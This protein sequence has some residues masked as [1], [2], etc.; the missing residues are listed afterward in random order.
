MS[1]SIKINGK[2]CE[3]TKAEAKMA[4]EIRISSIKDK[5]ASYLVLTSW[6]DKA[7]SEEAANRRL[8]VGKAL[9]LYD[10]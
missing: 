6:V 4:E 8:A 2:K 5:G 3:V 10:E 9:G 7:G 1:R